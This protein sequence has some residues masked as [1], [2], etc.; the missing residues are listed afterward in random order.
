MAT[1]PPLMSRNFRLR[2]SR[3]FA[4]S[5]SRC[6]SVIDSDSNAAIRS[7]G[8]LPSQSWSDVT[9]APPLIPVTRQWVSR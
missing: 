7:T 2:F 8:V 6:C 3:S 5:T 1:L 4:A 9:P